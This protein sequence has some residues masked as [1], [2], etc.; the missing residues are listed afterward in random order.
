MRFRTLLV[1]L[2]AAL[3]GL[4]MTAR[5]EVPNLTPEQLERRSETIVIGSVLGNFE[6]DEFGRTSYITRIRV[7]EAV[8][9][10]VG[11]GEEVTAMWFRNRLMPLTTGTGGHRGTLPQVGSAVKVHINQKGEA[12]LP[13]GFQP[14]APHVVTDE[15]LGLAAPDAIREACRNARGLG[16]YREII[17]GMEHL[18]SSGDATEGDLLMLAR[19][20]ASVGDYD[21]AAPI[22]EQ[23]ATAGTDEKVRR[24]ARRLYLAT[25]WVNKD[26]NE[27]L[28]AIDRLIDG[29]EGEE[30]ADLERYRADVA[31]VLSFEPQN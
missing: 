5:A 10:E 25:A 26:F 23:I 16:L 18:R 21:A 2:L 8:K 9:G 17:R 27:L 28:R 1:A 11:V 3:P 31:R 6:R 4:A 20:Y 12:L 24:D 13:N 15:L 14:A 7:L 22:A 29:S 30:K 19:A